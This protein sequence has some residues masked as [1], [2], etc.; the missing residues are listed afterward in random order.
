[1]RSKQ[2]VCIQCGE[3]Y[4]LDA[5]FYSDGR[6]GR[7]RRCIGC[8]LTRRHNKK[9]AWLALPLYPAAAPFTPLRKP[10]TGA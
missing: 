9:R 8:T 6:G 1:M 5:F 3:S 7:M 4:D 10:R 2:R